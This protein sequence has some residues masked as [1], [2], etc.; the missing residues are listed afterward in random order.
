MAGTEVVLMSCSFCNMMGAAGI[1][2]RPRV[3]GKAVGAMVL[4]RYGAGESDIHIELDASAMVSVSSM[5][6][7]GV[8]HFEHVKIPVYVD[9]YAHGVK[10]CPFC[11]EGL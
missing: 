8:E 9:G 4:T 6:V 2:D 1:D 5:S 3:E 10:Y 11:G 7:C